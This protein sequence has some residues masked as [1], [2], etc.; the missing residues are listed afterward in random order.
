MAVTR[1]GFLSLCL[2]L[3]IIAKIPAQ[4]EPIV[5]R[6]SEGEILKLVHNSLYGK[7]GNTTRVERYSFTMGS[8]LV[9]PGR[10]ALL[11]GIPSTPFLIQRL[12][13]NHGGF[14]ILHMKS[15]T[16]IPLGV[17]DENGEVASDYFGVAAHRPELEYAAV[18]PET[19]II[20][21]AVNRNPYPV[22]LF[23]SLMGAARVEG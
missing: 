4:A 7:F 11:R 1:R 20:L 14:G 22:K 9:E 2:S 19:E 16:E 18:D 10:I 17:G 5:K 12:I 6:A 3:P 23:A 13:M 8:E 15:G 21:A